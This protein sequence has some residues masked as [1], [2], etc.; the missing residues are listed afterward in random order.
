MNEPMTITR[1]AYREGAALRR[2]LSE[3]IE[4]PE[5]I[6]AWMHVPN[7]AFDGRTPLRVIADGDIDLLWRMVHDLSETSAT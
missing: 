2:A 1:N 5:R 7:P 3:I 4:D 6:D